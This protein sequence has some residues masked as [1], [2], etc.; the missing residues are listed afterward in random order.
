M[1][2][3][4]VAAGCGSSPSGVDGG[5]ADAT[6]GL[7]EIVLGSTGAHSCARV[8]GGTVRCWGWNEFG[9]LGDGSMTNQLVPT[10]LPLTDVEEVS[11]GNWLSK[12]D[13]DNLWESASNVKAKA[14]KVQ[15]GEIDESALRIHLADGNLAGA[16]DK[17]KLDV[18]IEMIPNIDPKAPPNCDYVF[19]SAKKL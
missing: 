7:T 3:L 4:L 17:I 13:I 10:L 9:Q 2:V 1:L 6:A 15:E 14:Y 5:P 12:G 8:S 19:L 18:A 16:A 11:L